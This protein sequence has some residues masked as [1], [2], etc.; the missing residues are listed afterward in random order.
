MERTQK[1]S[2]N[3]KKS[4]NKTF[5]DV[6]RTKDYAE[7]YKFIQQNFCE[8]NIVAESSMLHTEPTAQGLELISSSLLF[9]SKHK[10]Y[11]DAIIKGFQA[12]IKV[13]AERIVLQARLSYLSK[14]ISCFSTQRKFDITRGANDYIKYQK[15]IYSKLALLVSTEITSIHNNYFCWRIANV[16]NSYLNMRL[17]RD[18]EYDIENF[19]SY[20]NWYSFS[21]LIAGINRARA[22]IETIKYE[23]KKAQEEDQ[24]LFTNPIWLPEYLHEACSVGDL[25]LVQMILEKNDNSTECV[26]TMDE[27]G[28]YPLHLAC[29]QGNQEVIT[30]LLKAQANLLLVDTNGQQAIHYAFMQ[31]NDINNTVQIEKNKN[32]LLLLQ[33][34]KIFHVSLDV[35]DK[36][37]A[38]LLHYAV[39]YDQ[40]VS[41]RWLIE[42][43]LDVNAADGECNTP[44]HCAIVRG[45][46]LAMQLLL[47]KG[48]DVTLQNKNQATPLVTLFKERFSKKSTVTKMDFYRNEETINIF[49]N[50]G[51][52]LS[53][54]DLLL[55]ERLA[56]KTPQ[57]MQAV[58]LYWN[59][60][61]AALSAKISQFDTPES[62]L[63]NSSKIYQHMLKA[64]DSSPPI[65][66]KKNS[67]NNFDYHTRRNIII[68]NTHLANTLLL[69]AGEEDIEMSILASRTP[70]VFDEYCDASEELT[71]EQR[72]QL[73]ALDEEYKQ[74]SNEFALAC[75]LGDLVV[76][77]EFIARVT[78]QKNLSHIVNMIDAYD[79]C[80]LH[81]ACQEGHFE[82]AKTLLKVGAHPNRKD[83]K[84][85]TAIHYAVEPRIGKDSVAL[86]ELLKQWGAKLNLTAYADRSVLHAAA[87]FGNLLAVEWLCQQNEIDINAQESSQFDCLTALHKAVSAGHVVV[88][89]CLL[90]Y[91]VNARISNKLGET[92][93]VTALIQSNSYFPAHQLEQQLNYKM[94][95]ALFVDKGIFIS[96]NDLNYLSCFTQN[97]KPLLLSIQTNLNEICEENIK[98]CLASSATLHLPEIHADAKPQS[99][100]QLH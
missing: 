5:A 83:G 100:R 9:S 19:H 33:L 29:L 11:Q 7:I 49:I 48:A 21:S 2:L 35:I 37:G 74:K 81:L 84:G 88:V 55:L 8:E 13:R 67:G 25:A 23:R 39:K 20:T 73:I 50:H 63:A 75:K 15:E 96:N 99:M 36:K 38:G 27:R 52:I 44:L 72:K 54:C 77:N 97:K 47:N 61:Y 3:Q 85:Y 46:L 68:Q 31:Y 60:Y 86:L 28:N 64:A 95:V 92:P 98:L 94:I 66:F 18:D 17:F 71:N 42:Q 65:L 16:E 14:M 59:A 41:L 32:T 82:I 58:N 12:E 51:I 79:E 34:L 69:N 93:F 90:S 6:I 53:N 70:E 26:N 30:F 57:L 43:G 78:K 91:H 87:F 56:I 40:S 89:D 10:T 4:D 76:V 1:P 45:E 62:K 80:P 22:S 24:K